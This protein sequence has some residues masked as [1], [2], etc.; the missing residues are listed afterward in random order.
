MRTKL[1]EK[2]SQLLLADATFDVFK[3]LINQL[4]LFMKEKVKPVK[5]IF[6]T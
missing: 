2:F 1:Y 5:S 4:G 6:C 3:A